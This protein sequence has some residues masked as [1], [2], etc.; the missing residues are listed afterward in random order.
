MTTTREF[1]LVIDGHVDFLTEMTGYQRV[2]S[3]P[4]GLN[5]PAAPEE[6]PPRDFL[7]ESDA[8]HVDLPRARRGG[9]GV[10]FASHW[11]RDSDA[12]APA[13][14]TILTQMNQLLRLVDRAQGKL[15]LVRTYADLEAC[16]SD[17]PLGLIMHFEGADPIRAD[18]TELRVF[19]EAGLRSL[20][21]VWSRPTVF[22]YGV[23]FRGET[24]AEGLTAAGKE[25][26]REC[27]RLGILVDVSHLNV[28]GFWDVAATCEGP[29]VATHSNA[30]SVSNHIRNLT[31]DQLKAL[32]DHDGLTGINLGV[33]FIRPDRGRDADV[34]IE[35]V[36][37]HIDHIARVVG[38]RHVAIGTD[39]DGA[40]PPDVLSDVTKLP[41]LLRALKAHGYGDDAIERICQGNWKRVLKQVWR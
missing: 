6:R 11:L 37:A 39:F 38:D 4:G 36:I 18:L 16:L 40:R 20:G 2:A 27:N 7:T 28:P 41:L 30:F 24:P 29:F 21:I 22:G 25:L 1:P 15:R 23:M 34:P 10:I 13:L 32:A 14:P 17:G 31:D 5:A 9:V 26:V 12:G 8:G 19:Y 3:V 35:M 33:G